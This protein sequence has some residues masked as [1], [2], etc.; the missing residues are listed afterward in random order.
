VAARILQV[1]TD[2]DRRGAQVFATDLHRAF[3]RLERDVRTVA[4]AP[5]TSGGLEVPVLGTSRRAMSTLVALRA[6]IRDSTVVLAHGSTTLPAC[7]VASI[8]TGVPFVYRQI[9]DSR[10]WAASRLRR[11]R[12][13]IALARAAAVV[14]L[15]D[16]SSRTLHDYLG[17][18]TERI[19]VIPNGVE[20][21][22]FA[23]VMPHDRTVA[24]AR[25]GLDADIY[26]VAYVGAL[27]PEKGVDRIVRASLHLPQCQFLVVGDGP[28][29]AALEASAAGDANVFFAGSIDDPR[30]AYCA[31][32][33]V[34]LPSR[35]GDSMPAT[36]IEAGM[37]GL[38]CISTD[39]EA[40]PDVVVD[41]ETG[42]ILDHSDE[43][44]WAEAIDF[45]ASGRTPDAVAM[46]TAARRRCLERFNID[47]VALQW[48]ATIDAI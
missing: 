26:T 2:T 1:V 47:A 28:E 10:F 29:R 40:I 36:L 32:D 43:L 24:R 18:R 34:V 31:A 11:W 5:G 41:G 21:T 6:E 48:A 16:G 42:M 8:G 45:F 37:C 44:G 35:G 22:R 13:R 4:L 20:P 14:A 27:A 19:R 33:L 46:G 23:P 7:A 3:E 38:P 30:E 25:F 15:W 9:S 39:I 17:V 12:V